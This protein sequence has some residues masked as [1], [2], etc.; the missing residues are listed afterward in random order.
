MVRQAHHER[1]QQF[2]VRPELAEGLNKRC[3]NNILARE[4]DMIKALFII[5]F[6]AIIISLGSA[7]YHL[8]KHKS[9]DTNT[10]SDKTVKALT[11]RIGLSIALFIL[12]AIALVSGLIQ[13]HG[14]GARM[15]WQK[16]TSDPSKK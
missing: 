12:V 13:P 5:I 9:E 3:L 1:N 16:M 4:P 2:I 7:L 14:I 11:F 10:P 15:Y 8:V 6:L